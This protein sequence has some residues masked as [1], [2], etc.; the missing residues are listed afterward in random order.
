MLLHYTWV[1]QLNKLC[2]ITDNHDKRTTE[3]SVNVCP[4]SAC[5]D[6]KRRTRVT[7]TYQQQQRATVSLLLRF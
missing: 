5:D 3:C 2:H 7:K 1:T 4:I 6:P